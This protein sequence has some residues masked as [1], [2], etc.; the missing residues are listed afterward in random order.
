MTK[1]QL[2]LNDKFDRIGK[3]AVLGCGSTPGI[4][5]VMASY[6][7]KF[8]DRVKSLDITFADKNYLEH[9]Q[10]FI[11]PYSFRTILDEFIEAPAVLK[12]GRMIFVKAGEGEKTYDFGIECGI[13]KG[14]YS[15]HSELATLPKFFKKKGIKNCEFRATFDENFRSKINSLIN[16]GFISEGK[17]EIDSEKQMIVEITEKIMNKLT[18][19][20]GDKIDDREILRVDFNKG[21]LIIDA[22]AKSTS[23]ISAGVWDTAAPCSIIAQMASLEKIKERGVFAPEEVIKPEEFFKELRKRRIVILKNGI[24]V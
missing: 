7:G 12:N 2:E 13:V 9:K 3:V 16:A 20:K 24:I 14:V 21:K 8:L 4:T 10:R 18:L 23:G 1:R 19:K 15:L 17:I 22:M 5:N 11:L 6:G